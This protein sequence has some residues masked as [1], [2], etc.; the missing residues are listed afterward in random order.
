MERYRRSYQYHRL[1][2]RQDLEPSP[3]QRMEIL[4]DTVP[5]SLGRVIT[6][7]WHDPGVQQVYGLAH[8][9]QLNETAK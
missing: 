6:N 2:K 7:L 1:L 9:F 4:E 5:E 8:Q 3:G